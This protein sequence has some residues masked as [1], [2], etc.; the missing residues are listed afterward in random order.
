M[1]LSKNVRLTSKEA[2]KKLIKLSKK[3]EAEKNVEDELFKN[4]DVKNIIKPLN[5]LN[6]RNPIVERS[7][8]QTQRALNYIF[9]KFKIDKESLDYITVELL[10]EAKNSLKKRNEYENRSRQRENDRKKIINKLGEN[11]LEINS[12]NIK[13]YRLWTEQGKKCAYSGKT[14]DLKNL[15]DFELEHIIP[16]SK[17]GTLDMFNLLLS[18]KKLN[19]IKGNRTPR[20]A[21]KDTDKWKNVEETIKELEKLIKPKKDKDDKE[22]IGK[23][24]GISVDKK[25]IKTKIKILKSEESAEE[26]AKKFLK[27]SSLT[28]SAYI[29][30]EVNRYLTNRFGE[31]KINSTVGAITNFVR[32]KYGIS[33][34]LPEVRVEEGKA[35]YDK[36][37]KIIIKDEGFTVDDKGKF[38]FTEDEN[39]KFAI[40]EGKIIFE[41]GVNFTKRCDHRNHGIDAYVIALVDSK[42]I[43][44]LY[45]FNKN[46]EHLP[47]ED[48]D[49]K[50]F[51]NK[52]SYIKKD[53]KA[54]K[55]VVKNYVVWHKSDRHPKAEMFKETRYGANNKRT[56]TVPIKDLIISKDKKATVKNIKEKVIKEDIKNTLLETIENIDEKTLLKTGKSIESLS[57]KIG[58][59]EVKYNELNFTK[60]VNVEKLIKKTKDKGYK[61]ATINNIKDIVVEENIKKRLLTAI[62]NI[63]EETIK[64]TAKEKGRN[65]FK[66]TIQNIKYRSSTIKKVKIFD[67]DI[68]DELDKE[69]KPNIGIKG[70]ENKS[71]YLKNSGYSAVDIKGDTATLLPN[72][73]YNPKEEEATRIFPNDIVYYKNDFY[74]VKNFRYEPLQVKIA[75]TT[76]ALSFGNIKNIKNSKV[77]SASVGIKNINKLTLI[78]DRKEMS[79]IIKNKRNQKQ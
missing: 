47:K 75:L 74:A 40:Y 1:N 62:A 14:I 34:V 71:T 21:F 9:K 49:V 2:L 48:K 72:H 19:Q 43:T 33:K 54:L 32:D 11:K 56:K 77:A 3:E 37:R 23:T 6:L 65:I 51:Y 61:E 10:R 4:H 27:G 22:V 25:S 76:E 70:K 60:R 73:K 38:I 31:S 59:V 67:G 8:K 16:D 53:I 29:A 69:F 15:A 42:M 17:R 24:G 28:D 46:N 35:L 57:S 44:H 41:K 5:K 39:K 36:E 26:L 63:D 20:Q 64:E 45:E 7:L 18:D 13:R 52:F 68:R 30:K 79:N 58:N 50:A 78:K 66:E 12:N 55:E